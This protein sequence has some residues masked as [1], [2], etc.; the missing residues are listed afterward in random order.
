MFYLIGR[1]EPSLFIN[2]MFSQ[3]YYTDIRFAIYVRKSQEDDSRQ[4]QSIESQIEVLTD[5][6]KKFNLKIVKIYEDHASAY[7]PNNRTEFTQLV[8]DIYEQ[9]IDGILCWKADRLAR[10]Y[11]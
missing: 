7:K 6:A 2:K 9:K 4:V 10:N 5:C 3:N 8:Q 11:I 1:P